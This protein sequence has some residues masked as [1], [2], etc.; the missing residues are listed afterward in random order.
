MGVQTVRALLV[1]RNAPHAVTAAISAVVLAWWSHRCRSEF[2]RGWTRGFLEGVQAPD[3]LR[4]GGV[5]ISVIREATTGDPHPEPWESLTYW[6]TPK[7]K[8]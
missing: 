4:Q 7:V 1:E 6:D 5:P 2:R 3:E 8:E